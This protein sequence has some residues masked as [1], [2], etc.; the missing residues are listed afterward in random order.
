VAQRSPRQYLHVKRPCILAVMCD[1]DC[2]QR[3]IHGTRYNTGAV[4]L[5]A[6]HSTV[7][8][9]TCQVD[10]EWKRQMRLTLPA[11]SHARCVMSFMFCVSSFSDSRARTLQCGPV[12]SD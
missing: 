6:K 9:L 2:I 5:L 11:G 7:Y 8:N 4:S 3:S 1:C 10:A 12:S